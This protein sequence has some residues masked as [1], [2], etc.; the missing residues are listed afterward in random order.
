[1]N[2]IGP[3]GNQ[4]QHT[5]PQNHQVA[6]LDGFIPITVNN[7]DGLGANGSS[8]ANPVVYLSPEQDPRHRELL[9]ELKHHELL[10][11]EDINCLY[12]VQCKYCL[13]RKHLDVSVTS[14]TSGDVSVTSSEDQIRSATIKGILRHIKE[15]H[16][17]KSPSLKALRDMLNASNHAVLIHPAS[18]SL[19][20]FI[21]NGDDVAATISRIN[22]DEENLPQAIPILEVKEGFMC[23]LC[24]FCSINKN[25]MQTHHGKKHKGDGTTSAANT[26]SRLLQQVFA[27]SKK[28]YFPVRRQTVS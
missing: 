10:W 13:Q 28:Q 15:K 27:A 20:S 18:A 25:T 23:S 11:V 5:S 4:S 14:V 26:V 12:C 3:V 1:M 24:G 7:S 22:C 9:Q 8:V 16:K 6:P 17:K 2:R 19:S 21:M